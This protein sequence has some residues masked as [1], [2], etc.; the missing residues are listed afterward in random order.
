MRKHTR[1]GPLSTATACAVL[2]TGCS[3]LPLPGQEEPQD[4]RFA[5]FTQYVPDE[6]E[7][8]DDTTFVQDLIPGAQ[9]SQAHYVIQHRYRNAQDTR[10]PEPDRPYWFHAVVSVRPATTQ[11]LDDASTGTAALLPPVHPD[12]HHHVPH[13]CAFTTVPAQDANQILDTTNATLEGDSEQFTLDE[14]AV[15]TSCNL[16]ILTGTGTSS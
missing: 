6:L 1:H 5:D 2:L 4:D 8:L 10:L 3:V 16:I 11:A 13:H 15:S 9:A 12:L 7:V 14:L